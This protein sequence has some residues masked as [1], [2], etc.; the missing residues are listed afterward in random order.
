MSQLVRIGYL[1]GAFDMFRIDH[2]AQITAARAACEFLFVG[3]VSD[4]LATARTGRPPVV[5]FDDRLSIV[6]SMR[7]VGAA[8]GQLTDDIFEAWDQLR[9]DRL[10]RVPPFPASEVETCVALS[11][12]LISLIGLRATASNLAGA[13]AV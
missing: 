2:L 8:I 11:V 5:R 7:P 9:F 3:V 6:R 13:V 10:F 1:A 12:E 4:E